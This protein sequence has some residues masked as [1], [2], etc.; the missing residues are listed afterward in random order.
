MT[1]RHLALLPTIA[2][3]AALAAQPAPDRR[4]QQVMDR[5]EFAHASWGMEFYD[6]GAKKT[7]FAVNRDRLFVPG[8]TTKLLTMGT[9]F[10]VL[11]AD[12]RFHTR[13]YR[14]GPVRGGVVAGD[15]VLVASGD[16]NLSGRERP[17]GSYAFVDQDHSYG[18]QPLPTDPLTTLRHIAQQVAA[19]G[20][21]TVTGQV[22]VDASL[23][24]EGAR[25]LG[26]RVTMSP[27]VIND[28]VIDIVVA[29]AVRSGDPAAVTV[30][31][32]TS[33]LTVFANLVTADSGRPAAVRTVEDST[34]RDHRTLVITGSVPRGAP[35]NQRWVV[36]APS[37]FGEIVFAEL[38][39][40]AGVRAIPRLAS[41]TVDPLALA[42]SYADSLVVAE[43]VSLPL[44]AAARV[45]LK[46]S[47]NLHAS[48]MPLLLGALPVARDSGKTGFD[49]ARGWLEKAGLD[50]NGAVQGDGAGGDA[51]FSPAFMSRYLE[52][53]AGRP[54]A[55]VFKA[56]LP[57][58]GRD[59]TLAA[60]QVNAPAAGKV[61]AKTGTFS[62]FDPLNRRLIVHGKGL[63]GY[64]TSKSGR[65]IAFAIY[66]NNVAAN[67]PDP[68]LM[69]GQALGEIASIAWEVI[70]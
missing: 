52:L 10:E 70:K 30:S 34:D 6:L 31:P 9:A 63:A 55:G 57:V 12:H 33:Y 58:L 2:V 48:N 47:Q 14:T 18:G 35:T 4:I 21:R 59:G 45:L 5:P 24:R 29:P 26:T 27:V 42:R 41:R 62:S 50:L 8:S 56:A 44:S 61:F 28:N 49:L 46:T 36:P 65:E 68:A 38:L 1:S 54:W 22:I 15:L 11:G 23:F 51:F 64:F 32:R 19:R 43:H 17:D 16:P 3:A 40:E 20:I 69:S 67:V 25:E 60:I 66:V 7:A 53:I 13:I 37:R 39:N